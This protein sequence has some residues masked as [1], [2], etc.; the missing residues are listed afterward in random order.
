[1]I[2]SWQQLLVVLVLGIGS[3]AVL[4]VLLKGGVVN[5]S[6][7]GYIFEAVIC[8]AATAVLVSYSLKFLFQALPEGVKLS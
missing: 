3:G 4:R 5:E 2:V 1:M 6:P 8:A 7:F